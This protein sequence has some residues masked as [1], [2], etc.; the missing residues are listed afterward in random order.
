MESGG[1][2]D[3]LSHRGTVGNKE[4]ISSRIGDSKMQIADQRIEDELRKGLGLKISIKRNPKSPEKGRIVID[5]Y[6]KS[7]LSEI[8]DRLRP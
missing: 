8:Y 2:I 3:E 1:D 5:F 6:S 7:D 4:E